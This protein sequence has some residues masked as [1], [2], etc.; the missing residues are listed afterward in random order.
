VRDAEPG[1]ILH[2]T[3]KCELALLG[4]VPFARYYGSIDSTPLFVALAGLYW[5]Y[6]AD[7]ATLDTI[8]PNVKAAL[9]WIDRSGD[10]DGDGFVEYRRRRESGLVNQGW[11]DSGDA[12]FHED[13]RLADAPIALC[14]VQGYV[15]MART[16]AARM[17]EARG[18]TGLA[19]QLSQQAATLRERFE[20]QFWDEELGMYVLALD[21]QKQPCRVRTSNAG[22]LL[23]TG[24]ASPA[25]AAR[26]ATVLAS[27]DML[28]GWGIRTVSSRERRFNPTSYH[29]GS[30]WPHDNALIALGLA[31][32]G[33]SDL[34]ARISA[35][36]FDAAA[37]ME[38]RRLP[39]LFC[40]M[41]RQRDKGPILYPV[42]CSPQAWAA[43]APFGSLQA[44]IGLEID[45][46]QRVARFRYP[47]LPVG[48]D[49]LEIRGMPI[50]E[51]RVDLLLRRHDETVS[52]NIL[53]RRGEAEILTMQK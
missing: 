42:A 19:A 13:G 20:A 22:Q 38:M 52:V 7:T 11:K 28:T 39:E 35:S 41:R 4:D 31:R 23:F 14:E 47:R 15:Y 26:M 17:A 29:N 49:S 10:P 53:R 32:Y 50:G 51:A 48:I 21:G 5:Q 44:C 30:I 45:A 9:Q 18:E 16:L 25:R 24:I 2:E 8:W 3:R 1:K 27:S 37:H 36:I 40:G 33:Q 34:A 43:A 6:T 46:T 12:V